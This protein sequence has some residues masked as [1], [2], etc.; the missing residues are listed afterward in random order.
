[1]LNWL[2]GNKWFL[3]ACVALVCA[4]VYFRYEIVLNERAAFVLDR[5]TG[6]VRLTIGD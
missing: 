5:V 2:D 1:M 4:L 3:L 6:S